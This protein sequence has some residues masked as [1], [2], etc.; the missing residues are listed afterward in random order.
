MDNDKEIRTILL[1]ILRV[2]LLRIRTLGGEGSAQQCS[3]EADHLHNLPGLVE[4]LRP[5]EILYYYD[6]ERPGFLRSTTSNTDEFKPLWDQ[7]G[8]LIRAAKSI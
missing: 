1:R 3:V 4:S 2:G 6:V 8:E 7:L 5:K